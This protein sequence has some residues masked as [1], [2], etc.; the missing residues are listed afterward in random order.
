MVAADHGLVVSQANGDIRTD[1][2]PGHRRSVPS[3][4]APHERLPQSTGMSSPLI[5]MSEHPG[6]DCAVPAVTRGN[7]LSFRPGQPAYRRQGW[8]PATERSSHV[9]GLCPWCCRAGGSPCR[10]PGR[11][12]AWPPVPSGQ[13]ASRWLLP[14]GQRGL[15]AAALA[16]VRGGRIKVIVARRRAGDLA[17]CA[18]GISRRPGTPARCLAARACRRPTSAA[19]T[20][21]VS[22][23]MPATGSGWDAIPGPAPDDRPAPHSRATGPWA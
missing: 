13:G 23:L 12:A 15:S 14:G 3:V 9:R 1:H 5:G 21:T 11:R 22:Q 7:D 2:V 19:G 10:S 20:R 18:A 8:A 17:D 16:R 4:A 6:G